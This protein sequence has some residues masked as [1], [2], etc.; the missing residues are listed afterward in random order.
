MGYVNKGKI[1]ERRFA[2]E[3]LGLGNFREASEY[4]DMN[5]HWDMLDLTTNLKYDIKSIKKENRTDEKVDDSIHWVEL[6][7]VFSGKETFSE[8]DKKEMRTPR[9]GWLFGNADFFIFET[10]DKW[11]E[12]ERKTLQKY[13]KSIIV[14]KNKY[15]YK[16]GVGFLYGRKEWCDIAKRN[17][18]YQN[19][20][21]IE[22][23]DLTVMVETK[24]L[25]KISS[26][27]YSKKEEITS[28]NFWV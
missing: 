4:E 17:K 18:V 11:V 5:F 7:A 21:D 8:D 26:K 9:K 19:G 23:G 6:K 24:D 22:R 12:V 20:E 25:I 27:I 10:N 28:E 3:V 13:I 16:K 14:D 15:F 2:R 1:V